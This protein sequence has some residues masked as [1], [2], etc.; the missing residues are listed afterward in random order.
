MKSRS[1][2]V[3]N[4]LSGIMKIVVSKSMQIKWQYVS[5]FFSILCRLIFIAFGRFFMM[6][7]HWFRVAN[8]STRLTRNWSQSLNTQKRRQPDLRGKIL[9][10]STNPNAGSFQKDGQYRSHGSMRAALIIFQGWQI[11]NVRC[12]VV[13]KCKHLKSLFTYSFVLYQL[14]NVWFSSF[15]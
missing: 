12:S 8:L 15:Q 2:V 14:G 9:L 4:Q 10:F 13:G 3:F 7:S 5:L 11:L 6:T 1:Q